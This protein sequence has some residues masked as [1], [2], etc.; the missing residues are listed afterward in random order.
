MPTIQDAAPV[1]AEVA[2]LQAVIGDR[3]LGSTAVGLAFFKQLFHD[4]YSFSPQLF[5]LI[6]REP[7]LPPLLL[8]GHVRPLVAALRLMQAHVVEGLSDAQLGFRFLAAHTDAAEADARLASLQ[9]VEQVWGDGPLPEGRIARHLTELVRERAAPSEHVQWALIA[10]VQI[11]AQAL[12]ASLCGSSA[13]TIGRL[14]RQAF[15]RW[16]GNFPLDP[17]WTSLSAQQ[18]RA[19]LQ[20]LESLLLRTPASRSGFRRRLL[21]RYGEAGS[22]ASLC[23]DEVPAMERHGNG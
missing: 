20:T 19:E 10:P 1:R 14:L 17:V 9:R 2:A 4:Y 7:A 11:Y 18:A 16:A 12:A 6:V 13:T 23:G 15:E 5:T 22:L 8:E 21:Q 3:F